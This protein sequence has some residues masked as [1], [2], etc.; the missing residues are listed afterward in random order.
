L[1]TFKYFVVVNT[2]F[3]IR[4]DGARRFFPISRIGPTKAAIALEIPAIN[5]DFESIHW[6]KIFLRLA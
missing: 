4:L 2:F 3:L 5:L 1:E 6:D